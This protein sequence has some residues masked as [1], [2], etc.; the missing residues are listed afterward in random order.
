MIDEELIEKFYSKLFT[1]PRKRITVSIGLATILLASLLNGTVSKTFFAQRYFFIGLSLIVCIFI[2]ALSLRMALNSRR[3]FFLSLFILI[4]VEIFDFIAIHIASNFNLI[5]MAPATMAAGLTLILY[6]TSESSELKTA[7]ISGLI[8]I[9][10]YPV[11]FLFS[12][13]APHRFLAYFTT[14]VVGVAFAFLFIKYLDRDYDG[15]NIKKLLRSFLLFWLTSEPEYFEN[16]LLKTSRKKK[17]WVKVLK[18]G[19][20]SLVSTSFHPGPLRNVGGARMVGEILEKFGNS[21]YLHS[22]AKHDS[23]PSTSKDIRKILKAIEEIEETEETKEI[24]MSNLTAVKPVEVEG[25]R[26]R[27]KIFPFNSLFNSDFNFTLIFIS[28]KKAIDDIPEVINEF[29]ESLFGECLVV[30]CH[31]CHSE[32]YGLSEEDLQEIKKLLENAK[33]KLRKLDNFDPVKDSVK[34]RYSFFKKK[35]ETPNICGFIAMLLLDYNSEKHCLLMLDGNNVNCEFKNQLEVFLSKNGIKGI[36]SSTDNHAKTAI[37]PK[38]GY[39]PVGSDKKER[40][41]ILEFLKEG[42]SSHELREVEKICYAKK[43]VEINVMGDDFFKTV[44]KAFKEIGEK[45]MYLFFAVIVLQ[46]AVSLILGSLIM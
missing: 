14:I 45:A 39:M 8:L 42:L 37:S 4:F 5:V 34:V 28:G 6:F 22:A 25:E 32:N 24:E 27:I 43:N 35:V 17:G 10:I 16:E 11:N 41:I 46:L 13:E 2:G 7:V 44:E 36:I 23:N 31:N 15:I 26:F 19:D 3:I 21:I 29:A 38:V 40:E 1:I 12:F 30:D 9:A 20:V 18:F 33:E